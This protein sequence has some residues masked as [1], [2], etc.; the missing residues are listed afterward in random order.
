VDP[1]LDDPADALEDSLA[2]VLGL[3]SLFE[4]LEPLELLDPFDPPA[5]T[6]DEELPDRLSVL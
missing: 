5:A 6:D 2:G 4:P 1:L 3:L